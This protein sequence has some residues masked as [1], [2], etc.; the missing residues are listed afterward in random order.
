M[1]NTFRV[2]TM[3]VVF[4]AAAAPAFAQD[5]ETEWLDRVTHIRQVEDAPVPA[6]PF[7]Y[8]LSAGFAVFTNDNIFLSDKK[9]TDDVIWVPYAQVRLEYA[10][11]NAEAVLD[12]LLSYRSY[13]S[14]LRPLE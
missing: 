11:P 6:L 3:L 7:T 5:F 1:N 12:T 9:E 8:D 14:E 13:A 2:A 4:L 10:E